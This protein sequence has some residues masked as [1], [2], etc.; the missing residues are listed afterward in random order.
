MIDIDV[1]VARPALEVHAQVSLPEHG[2]NAIIGRSGAGKT[3]LMHAVAGLLRPRRGHVRIGERT[4]FDAARGVDVATHAR[5]LGVVFQDGRLF[6][7][8]SVRGNLRYAHRCGRRGGAAFGDV[9]AL[10]GIE[11]LLDRRAHSL[12]GGER[13]R[14]AIGRALLAAPQ[15]LLMDEPLASLDPARRHELLGYLAELPRR[16]NVPV[17]YV[18]HQIDEVLRLADHVVVMDAGR[19]VATG[20]ALDILSDMTLQPLL[21]RFE[22]GSV[23]VGTIAEQLPE[24]QLTR[25]RLAERIVTVPQITAA[26]GSMVRL[27]VRARDVALQRETLSTSAS[28]QLEGT[29]LR[30]L[31]REGPYCAVEL[32]LGAQRD[33][34][35]RLWAL[36]TRRSVHTLGIIPGVRA[37]ASFKAVAVEGR[38][39][40]LRPSSDRS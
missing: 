19:T 15:A 16:F 40:A 9:V 29:V 12:S 2:I 13:Q 4:L 28:N 27:R 10:L 11:A 38:A 14:V 21:G 7:H 22:S 5:G 39:I 8:L 31:V 23:L 17:L 18:T 1:V 30:V 3:T 20:P 34:G 35:E 6:P 25:V 26:P 33:P 32:D 36:V 24:W 37:V